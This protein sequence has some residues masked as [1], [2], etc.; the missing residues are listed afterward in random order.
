MFVHCRDLEINVQYQYNA[1]TIS[2]AFVFL[3]DYSE[4]L[5]EP[6]IPGGLRYSFNIWDKSGKFMEKK[7]K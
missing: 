1:Y 6:I 4:T 2:L 7:E 3:F 5:T